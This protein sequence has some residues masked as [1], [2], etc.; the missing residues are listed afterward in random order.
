MVESLSGS[1]EI[2]PKTILKTMKEKIGEFVG[3][4]P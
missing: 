1:F 4:V 3:E 2:L